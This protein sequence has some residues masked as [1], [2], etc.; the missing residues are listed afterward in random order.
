MNAS[1]EAVK[2]LE[3]AETIGTD[4]PWL[5]LNRAEALVDLHR[6]DEAEVQLRKLETRYTAVTTRHAMLLVLFTKS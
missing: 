6:L 5:Y 2:V 4:N 1:K 3:K